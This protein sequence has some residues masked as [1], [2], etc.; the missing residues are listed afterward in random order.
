MNKRT[1]L[2]INLGWEQEPLIRTVMSLGFRV[3]GITNDPAYSNHLQLDEVHVCDYRDLV[4]MVEL[5][6]R[7]KPDYVMADQCDYSYFAVSVIAERFGLPGPRIQEAQVAT[8]KWLQRRKGDASGLLQPKFRLVSSVAEAQQAASDLG[9]PMILKPVDNRGSFGVNKIE[10]NSDIETAFVDALANSHSR[11][12]LAEEF[13]AGTHIT[14]DGYCFPKAGHRSLTLATK[15]MLGGARQVAIGIIYPGELS[16]DVYR[17]AIANNEEVVCKL[18]FRFG[19]TH[20]EYMI[21]ANGRSFLIEIA[22]RGG[23]C[24][25]SAKIV[26]AVS[27]INVT[28]QLVLD[29]IGA[30]RDLYVEQHGGSG[31][32]AYLK[33][34][35][36]PPGRIRQISG[37]DR[38]RG[39]A[40]V[41]A[42]WLRLSNGDVVAP[43]T[44][45]A[46]RH[47]FVITTGATREES[48]A[49]AASVIGALG[50]E[51]D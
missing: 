12:V 43:T 45:D 6:E 9:L 36:L 4:R 19:M 28:E 48:R 30:G 11:L 34:F 5:A 13:I 22:N 1:A 50:V 42:L 16:A 49:R 7:I 51:Y 8:N 40:G 39:M 10:R 17:Q 20:A 18:G 3:V 27:G 41:E 46:D 31:G 29:S 32:S 23:G 35:V 26:P 44:T 2:V 37:I 21:D 33:F 14:I 25:T 24:Y 47:G 15:E 38:A